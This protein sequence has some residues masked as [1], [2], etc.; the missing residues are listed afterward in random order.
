MAG[1]A[2]NRHKCFIFIVVPLLR[3]KNIKER[4]KKYRKIYL[5]YKKKYIMAKS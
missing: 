3:L 4:W 1:I 5:K 2:Q